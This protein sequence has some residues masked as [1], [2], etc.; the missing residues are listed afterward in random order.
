MTTI[1]KYDKNKIQL[2]PSNYLQT[3]VTQVARASEV[4]PSNQVRQV[5]KASQCGVF[6]DWHGTETQ[7]MCSSFCSSEYHL[8]IFQVDL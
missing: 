4:S 8:H 7:N 6:T 2:L 5:R 1:E 3:D